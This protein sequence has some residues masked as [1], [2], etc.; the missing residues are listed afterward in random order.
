MDL[1]QTGESQL[2]EADSTG[3]FSSGARRYNDAETAKAHHSHLRKCEEVYPTPKA[4]FT[5]CAIFSTCGP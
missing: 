1:S 2:Q 4:A 5:S 3:I